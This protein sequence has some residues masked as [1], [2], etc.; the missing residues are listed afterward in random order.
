MTTFAVNPATI[1]PSMFETSLEEEIAME[2]EAVL[3]EDQRE[4][5]NTYDA[6]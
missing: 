2:K 1:F 4:E 6:D 5:G 3:Y